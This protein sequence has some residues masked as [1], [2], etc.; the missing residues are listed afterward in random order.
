VNYPTK[1]DLWLVLIIV[2]CGAVLLVQA[3]VLI[4]TKG[5]GRAETWI[6]CGVTLFYFGILR[7]LAYPVNYE[8]KGSTLEIHSGVFMKY[9]IPL[10][11]I[12]G[13]RPTRNPLSSPA[14]SLDRLRVEY[15]KNGRTRYILISPRE[16]EAFLRNLTQADPALQSRGNTIA[17]K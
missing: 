17:R 13:V 11:S 7:L 16:K 3:G 5:F 10:A 1:K 2:A 15:L 9:S 14:W 12:S 4:A 6:I 8:I